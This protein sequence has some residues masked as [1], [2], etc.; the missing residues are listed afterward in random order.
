MCPMPLRPDLLLIRQVLRLAGPLV[1]SMTGYML[2]QFIDGVFLSWHSAEAVAALGPAGMAA[3]VLGSIFMGASG[4]TGTLVAQYAGAGRADRIGKAVWQG[5]HLALACGLLVAACGPL[6][7]WLFAAVGHPAN[8]RAYEIQYFSIICY[9]TP[10]ALLATALSGFFSGRGD[11]RTLMVVQLGGLAVNAI[12]AWALIFGR[13]GLPA[14]NMAGA[15]VATVA[16]QG[17]V[18]LVL[19]ALFLHRQH[20]SAYAT[21]RG[22]RFDRDMM[23][24]LLRF[25]LPSGLRMGV[26]ILGWTLFLF[27]V[28]R[29]GTHEL[30]ATSIAWRINGLAFFPIIGLSEAIRIL[31][32]QA[33]GRGDT[34]TSLHVTIQ[35]TLIAE[36]WMLLAAA[37]FLLLP[38]E[39]YALFQGT[40]VGAAEFGA[41]R[42]TGVI[43]LRFVAV[44]CLM[45]SFNITLLGALMAAGDTRWTSAAACIL[46]LVFVGGLVLADHLRLG[47]Y[48]EWTWATVFVLAIAS[49]WIWRF[50]T[51]AWKTIRVIEGG[52]SPTELS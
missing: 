1:L 44:Y 8:V 35:G 7:H 24:R 11:T 20:P 50:R 15:A 16:A 47:L 51:G 17:T 3:F 23:G 34:T 37:V 6:G 48:A 29:L 33:Q 14:W 28:G 52:G 18:A 12:L 45:D 36:V 26:E 19:A 43:L 4:Y 27:F 22:W 10:L 41:I 38:R 49:V 31:V 46:Y 25:G 21:R 30:A 5:I 40:G 2:M 42:E 13:L 32:G 9:G 39:L